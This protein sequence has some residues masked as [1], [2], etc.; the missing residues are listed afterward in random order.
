MIPSHVRDLLFDH[1]SQRGSGKGYD[2]HDYQLEMQAALE[3]WAS[4]VEEL[5]AAEGVMLFR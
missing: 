4:R 3:A 2:P 1:A 5:V